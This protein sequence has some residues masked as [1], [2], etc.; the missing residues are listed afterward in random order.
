MAAAMKVL[1]AMCSLWCCANAL[2][3]DEGSAEQSAL[4]L[5]ANLSSEANASTG[6]DFGYFMVRRCISNRL[7]QWN[8]KELPAGI[9]IHPPAAVREEDLEALESLV[10]NYWDITDAVENHGRNSGVFKKL[11]QKFRSST[12]AQ[13]MK[14]LSDT[15][16]QMKAAGFDYS[17]IQSRCVKGFNEET[18]RCMLERAEEL[19]PKG[20]ALPSF[21]RARIDLEDHTRY[22][23]RYSKED[24]KSLK[25]GLEKARQT[26]KSM[27]KIG[28]AYSFSKMTKECKKAAEND[29]DTL[30]KAVI[31]DLSAGNST[32]SLQNMWG[33]GCVE[34]ADKVCPEGTAPIVRRRFDAVKG[35]SAAFTTFWSAQ[36]IKVVV[37]GL[38]GT[39]M[40]ASA[41]PAGAAA[42]F[43]AG[44]TV[45]AAVPG[46]S[47]LSAAAFFWSST[48]PLECACFPRDCY[49]DELNDV[50]ALESIPDAPS[51][52]PFGRSMPYAST[53]CV[54][55]PR[56]GKE[57]ADTCQIQACTA[58]DYAP[59]LQ[60]PGGKL[61][62]TIGSKGGEL[63]N[64]LS[65]DGTTHGSLSMDL[66]LW[67]GMNNTA[68]GRI[69]LFRSV[70]PPV[71][72]L[73]DEIRE[74]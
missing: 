28:F 65:N 50:C 34:A 47:A 54:R 29:I 57:V 70:Q 46:P 18:Y 30:R 2:R 22:K 24:L 45:A 52:N 66:K 74:Q 41:G 26:I 68:E 59:Q 56:K 7:A 60:L 27:P 12:R 71:L 13:L 72:E 62:G 3:A 6:N 67:N 15:E 10:K 8:L 19:A 39:I 73:P 23:G 48:G 1:I 43:A 32:S 51:R 20:S 49:L 9:L 21:V 5:E 53:K 42:G 36:A 25:E 31:Y 17:A 4:T 61:F 40:G 55:K 33:G 11:V 35:A 44:A 16:K 14:E 58:A 38:V 37:G 64:C 63:F 69:E